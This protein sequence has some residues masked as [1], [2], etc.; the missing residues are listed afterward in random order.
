[1]SDSNS[2][3]EASVRDGLSSGEVLVLRQF[4]DGT[5]G[6]LDGTRLSDRPT[7]EETVRLLGQRLRLPAR[8]SEKWSIDRTIDELEKKGRTYTALWKKNYLLAGQLLLLLNGDNETELSGLTLKYDF[9]NGLTYTKRSD[10]I[11]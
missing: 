8:F 11:E 1:M 6:F 7:K 3:A 10:D 2:S 9:N 5:I 4:D